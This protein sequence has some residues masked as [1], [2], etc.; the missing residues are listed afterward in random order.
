MTTD[1]FVELKNRQR[2]GWAH[3][4]PLEIFTMPVAAHL[5]RFAGVQPGQALL[6]VATGTG[7]V[8]IRMLR[9][10]GSS[11]VSDAATGATLW[12]HG[13]ML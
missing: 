5:V 7:V 13:I 1:P 10:A 9:M 2:Q 12:P 4:A 6:D 3:F 11:P 8:A